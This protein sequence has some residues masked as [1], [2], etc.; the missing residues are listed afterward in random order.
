LSGEEERIYVLGL[1]DG[2]VRVVA[3]G[4]LVGE[5]QTHEQ[6]VVAVRAISKEVFVSAGGERSLVL[7]AVNYEEKTVNKLQTV[8]LHSIC[9]TVLLD[10]E[11]LICSLKNTEIVKYRIS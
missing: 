7:H 8:E 4:Q 10:T 5:A 2:R 11:A 3:D 6:E 9:L 1:L